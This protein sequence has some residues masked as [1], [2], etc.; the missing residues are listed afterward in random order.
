[1]QLGLIVQHGQGYFVSKKCQTDNDIQEEDISMIDMILIISACIFIYIKNCGVFNAK[2]VIINYVLSLHLVK[3][4]FHSED[5]LPN[6]AGE[7]QSLLI[8]R[9]VL[10]FYER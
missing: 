2:D 6:D 7:E 5:S 9:I 10:F 4:D 1:M 8:W 3:F